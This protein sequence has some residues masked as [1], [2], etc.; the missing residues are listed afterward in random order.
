MSGGKHTT[1]G[2]ERIAWGEKGY[3]KK[4][5]RNMNLLNDALLYMDAMFDVDF[6]SLSDRDIIQWNASSQ[7]F[8]NVSYDSIFPSTT[9]TTT[10]TTTSSS[11]ASTTSTQSTTTSTQ[12]TTSS[13]HT[14][15][16]SSTTNS[17]T[18]TTTV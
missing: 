4:L 3:A 11:T 7:K 10:T 18:T 2:L 15:T 16:T 9:T 12:S 13:T 14:T 5:T 8:E 6:T 1:T 17:S